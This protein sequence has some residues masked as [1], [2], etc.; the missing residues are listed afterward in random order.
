MIPK[1]R[2]RRIGAAILGAA[3]L[4]AAELAAFRQFAAGRWSW[5]WTVRAS[6]PDAAVL[7]A[8]VAALLLWLHRLVWALESP[9]GDRGL[10]RYWTYCVVLAAVCWF[11][12]NPDR[13]LHIVLVLLAMVSTPLG[14]LSGILA[15]VL[16]GVRFTL[17]CGVTAFWSAG[18]ILTHHC[19]LR[20]HMAI[21][22]AGPCP[23]QEQQRKEER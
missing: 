5:D 19:L 6:L 7:A 1:T 12:G 10:R 22:R 8:I 9:T 14:L 2:D 4:W 17:C 20:R 16:G 21:H 23:E 18:E 13:S 11:Q 15:A 3:A